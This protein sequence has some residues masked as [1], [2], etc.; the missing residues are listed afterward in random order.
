M[1]CLGSGD[2]AGSP[3]MSCSPG[4][5]APGPGSSGQTLDL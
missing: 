3:L 1:G 5:S 2:G 4:K